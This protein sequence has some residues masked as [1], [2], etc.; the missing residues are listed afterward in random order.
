MFGEQIALFKEWMYDEDTGNL[1]CRCPDCGGRLTIGFYQ[2]HNPYKYCPYCGI[3]LEQ[4]RVTE[5]RR[6]VYGTDS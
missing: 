6:Q 3:R 4:G 2:Y 1:M 5:K